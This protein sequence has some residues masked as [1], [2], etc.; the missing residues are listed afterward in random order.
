MARAFSLV[1]VFFKGKSKNILKGKEVG[2]SPS[3]CLLQLIPFCP[4]SRL[5]EKYPVPTLAKRCIALT[6][7]ILTPAGG[8]FCCLLFPEQYFFFPLRSE[9]L[10]KLGLFSCETQCFVTSHIPVLGI[11][12]LTSVFSC[13]LAFHARCII[14]CN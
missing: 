13:F 4:I 5:P 6:E 11:D 10:R 1:L 7:Q 14:Y 9:K 12:C 2:K 3:F 8:D